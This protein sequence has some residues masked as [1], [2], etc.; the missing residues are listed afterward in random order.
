[1]SAVISPHLMGME[2]VSLRDMLDVR[3]MLIWPFPD[4]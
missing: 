4:Y 1:M 2:R 3:C